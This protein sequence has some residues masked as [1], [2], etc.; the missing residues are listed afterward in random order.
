MKGYQKEAI[1]AVKSKNEFIELLTLLIDKRFVMI[2]GK[3]EF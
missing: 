2:H 3:S 1:V